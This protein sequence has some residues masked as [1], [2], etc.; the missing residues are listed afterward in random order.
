MPPPQVAAAALPLMGIVPEPSWALPQMVDAI[1]VKMTGDGGSSTSS[2]AVP[3][4]LLRRLRQRPGGGFIGAKSDGQAQSN[5]L[6]GIFA[7]GLQQYGSSS[8]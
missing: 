8:R 7:H 2:S 1:I 6:F 5:K 4:A 3:M